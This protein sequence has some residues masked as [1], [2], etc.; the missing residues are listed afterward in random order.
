MADVLIR[1]GRGRPET[2]R[3]HPKSITE[4]KFKLKKKKL[5]L[6]RRL[7]LHTQMASWEIPPM[8][9]EEIV[10]VVQKLFQKRQDERIT[11]GHSRR[12]TLLCYP[13]Q[14]STIPYEYRCKY[15]LKCLQTEYSN[16]TG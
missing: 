8:F 10:P 11:P 13:N 12:Q 14:P 9:K 5:P 6:E 1:E 16:V 7:L 4:I 2:H 3:H 15:P